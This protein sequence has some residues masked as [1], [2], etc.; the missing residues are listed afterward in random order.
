MIL[1]YSHTY[2]GKYITAWNK[3]LWL[4]KNI[5]LNDLNDKLLTAKI[6]PRHVLF[7]FVGLQTLYIILLFMFTSLSILEAPGHS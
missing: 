7:L 4:L 6:H 1:E 3:F 5:L 2:H